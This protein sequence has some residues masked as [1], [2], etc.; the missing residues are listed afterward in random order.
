V[1]DGDKLPIKMLSDRVL[2]RLGA[3]EGERR[4]RLNGPFAL[5]DSE[6]TSDPGCYSGVTNAS[7]I[8]RR[9]DVVESRR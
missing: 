6:P 3:S 2:V 5:R 9:G 7:R 4:S 1:T 8:C